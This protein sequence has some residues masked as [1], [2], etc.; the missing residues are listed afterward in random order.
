MQHHYF[1]R[2]VGLGVLERVVFAEVPPRVEY[3]LT[4][5]GERFLPILD[6]IDGLQRS[7]TPTRRRGSPA[8][9]GSN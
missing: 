1:Q 9:D 7:S 6:S 3:R 5:F 2:M 4:P 8:A